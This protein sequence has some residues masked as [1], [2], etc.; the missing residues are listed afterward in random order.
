M[1][2]QAALTC[3]GHAADQCSHKLWIVYVGAALKVGFSVLNPCHTFSSFSC[4]HFLNPVQFLTGLAPRLEQDSQEDALLEALVLDE[5]GAARPVAVDGVSAAADNEDLVR[6]GGADSDAEGDAELYFDESDTLKCCAQHEHY[7]LRGD[8][9]FDLSLYEYAALI[10]VV[11]VDAAAQLKWEKRIK[12]ADRLARLSRGEAVSSTSMSAR[13]NQSGT[14]VHAGR[15]SNASYA[16][17]FGHPLRFSHKQ[18]LRSKQCIP[19]PVPRPPRMPEFDRPYPLPKGAKRDAAK[20]AAAYYVTMFRPWSRN[21]MPNTSYAAWSAWVKELQQS[22]SVNSLFRLAVMTRMSHGFAEARHTAKLQS[23]YRLRNVRYWNSRQPDGTAP[24]PGQFAPVVNDPA[25]DI[26]N[27]ANIAVDELAVLAARNGDTSAK[28]AAALTK[29]LNSAEQ[30]NGVLRAY[31]TATSGVVVHSGD[32]AGDVAATLSC[33]V[34]NDWMLEQDAVNVIAPE[35]RPVMLGRAPESAAMPDWPDNSMMSPSQL[36]ASNCIRQALLGTEAPASPFLI[37]GGP[38]T[39]KTFVGRYLASCCETLGVGARSAALAASAAGLLTKGATLHT[40]IGLGGRGKPGDEAQGGIPKDFSK[41]LSAD[42]LRK[43]RAKF[44]NVRLLIIDEISMVPVDLLGH[45]NH[46]LQVIMEKPN[47][48]F[49]GLVVVMMG[50]FRQLPP[51]GSHNLAVFVTNMAC[52]GD[53]VAAASAA[54]SA[55]TAFQAARVFFLTEQMRCSDA[56]WMLML[57]QC[58]ETGTLAPISG[59]LKPL[60]YDDCGRDAAWRS[61]TVATFGNRVRQVLLSCFICVTVEDAAIFIHHLFLA[62]HQ[63]STSRHVCT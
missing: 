52:A 59:K 6:D 34:D 29:A 47:I 20:R 60:T 27:D 4:P 50:D 63:C 2:A 45:V 41:P 3:L 57:H 46:R 62:E 26:D 51:V 24:P 38:G 19:V 15:K 49:G 61:A 13:S 42:K 1:F 28:D 11:K 37:I 31:F 17:A 30:L 21:A 35:V 33:A 16:F 55:V 54:A 10:A 14:R 23:A 48:L 7:A 12:A 40:L 56:D 22:G 39:G 9:L 36:E 43:L 18:T 32:P 25:G 58:S 5:E 53:A 44:R 8:E